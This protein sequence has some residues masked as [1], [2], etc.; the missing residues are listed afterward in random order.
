MYRHASSRKSSC[1]YRQSQWQIKGAD[2]HVLNRLLGTLAAS[3]QRGWDQ[4]EGLEPWLQLA[5]AEFV[6]AQP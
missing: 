5:A 2:G 4:V 6:V 3:R 1:R